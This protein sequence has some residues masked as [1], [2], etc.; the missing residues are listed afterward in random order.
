MIFTFIKAMVL[1]K[2]ARL[3][4]YRTICT[5]REEATRYTICKPCPQ[6]QDGQCRRCGCLVE[7]KTMLTTEQCPDKRWLRIWAKRVT[8]S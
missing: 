5:P 1:L 6:F 3:R 4:G 2:W 8:V 7:A